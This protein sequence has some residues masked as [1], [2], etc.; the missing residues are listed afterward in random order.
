[1]LTGAQRFGTYRTKVLDQQQLLIE[2]ITHLVL[3]N[4]LYDR[5][6]QTVSSISSPQKVSAGHEVSVAIKR[7]SLTTFY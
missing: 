3:F 1:M 7:E 2:K 5:W 4:Q 6:K